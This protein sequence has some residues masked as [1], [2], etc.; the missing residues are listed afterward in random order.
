MRALGLTTDS[1]QVDLVINKIF[2]VSEKMIEQSLEVCQ[3]GDD[4]YR[5]GKTFLFN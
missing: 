4:Q 5:R 2:A 3:G 1:T